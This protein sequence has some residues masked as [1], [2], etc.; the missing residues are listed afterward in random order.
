MQR[1]FIDEDLFFGDYAIIK[2]DYHHIKNVMRFTVGKEVIV[3]P[4]NGKAYLTKISSFSDNEVHVEVIEELESRELD[5]EVTLAIG[6]VNNNKMEL[7]IQKATELG[8]SKILPLNMTRCIIKDKGNKKDRFVKIAKEA[9]E[10]SHR[11]II[12]EILDTTSIKQIK[13]C[14]DLKLFAYEASNDMTS[15]VKSVR[16]AKK[17]IIVVGPEGGFDDKEV[18]LLKEMGYLEV[19]LGKRILRAETAAFQALGLITLIKELNYE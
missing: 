18:S 17:I 2:E 7:I 4:K 19:S 14:Y 15:L 1:Y 6:L 8:V 13:D 5:V 3:C 16:S 9:A 11:S 10:Q 12:P